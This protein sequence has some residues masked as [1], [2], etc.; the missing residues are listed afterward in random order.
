MRFTSA[1]EK[2]LI[3]SENT[4]LKVFRLQQNADLVLE[5]IS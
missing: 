4:A 2:H 5:P 3:L 1:L